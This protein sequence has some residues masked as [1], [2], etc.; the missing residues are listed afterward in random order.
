MLGAGFCER[1]AFLGEEVKK[2]KLE[3]WRLSPFTILVVAAAQLCD[4]EDE[5]DDAW[6]KAP[7]RM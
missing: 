4:D 6:G 1:N 5:D 2:K 7:V 3:S